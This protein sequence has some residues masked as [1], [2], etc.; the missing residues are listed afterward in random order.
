MLT[1]AVRRVR[2]PGVK[3]DTIVVLEG[4]QGSGKSTALGILAGEQNFSD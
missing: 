3:F 4:A 2:Q 1:A